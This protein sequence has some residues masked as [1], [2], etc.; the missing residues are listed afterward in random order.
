MGFQRIGVV[1]GYRSINTLGADYLVSLMRDDVAAGRY[2]WTILFTVQITSAGNIADAQG[3]A[4]EIERKDSRINILA[5]Y[6]TEGAMFLCQAYQRNLLSPA[7]NFMAASGW[8]N[9]SYIVERAGAGLR[10]KQDCVDFI[11]RMFLIV[12]VFS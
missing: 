8:W 2:N 3:A 1:V 9:P 6:Q 5:L 7:Y 12:R 11:V 10:R 4:E